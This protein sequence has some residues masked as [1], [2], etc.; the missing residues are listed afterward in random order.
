MSFKQFLAESKEQSKGIVLNIED[1]TVNNKNYRKVV[2][3]G[4]NLQL[5][6]MSLKPNEEIGEEIHNVDQFFRIDSGSGTFVLDGQKYDIKDGFAFT[7]PAN[8][9]HNVIAGSEGL[10]IYTIYAPPHHKAG[11]IEKDKSE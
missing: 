10:K 2:W 8:V 6:L 3:T 11:L 7:I 9:K 1:E 5:V 4:K